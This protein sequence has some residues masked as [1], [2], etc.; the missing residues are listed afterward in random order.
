MGFG[1]KLKGLRDQAQ[2]AVAE[3]KEKIQSAVETVGVAANEKTGGKYANKIMK[4]GE[5]VTASVE[6]VAAPGSDDA[7]AQAPETTEAPAA[8]ATS[9][10]AFAD[11]PAATF[12]D[13]SAP[14]F[15]DAP[16]SP[17]PEATPVAE[18]AAPTGGIPDFE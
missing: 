9:A 11:E 15:A 3:N 14:A 7:A 10:A 1:D 12:G 4:V 18:P 2:Q 17:S 16:A 8:E 6:K 5:K 13:A